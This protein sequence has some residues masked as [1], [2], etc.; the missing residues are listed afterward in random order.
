MPAE[1][2]L[3]TAEYVD[4]IADGKD[5]QYDHFCNM[6]IVAEFFKALQPYEIESP[7]K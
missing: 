2:Y 5:H 4:K 7:R 6:D 1:M 3:I